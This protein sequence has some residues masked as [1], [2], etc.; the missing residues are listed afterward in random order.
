MAK[1]K[2][3][4]EIGAQNPF[5]D[6][7]ADKGA[8]YKGEKKTPDMDA[9]EPEDELA[10]A[11]VDKLPMDKALD[12]TIGQG[13]GDQLMGRDSGF[14]DLMTGQSLGRIGEK[15]LS[16]AI[17]TLTKYKQG[18]A[19][20]ENRIVEDELWWEM[21]HWEAIGRGRQQ[22]GDIRVEPTSA[23]LFNAIINK[24]ADAM[25]NYPE[26]IVLPRERSDEQSAKL[27]SSVLPVIM[28]ANGFEKTYSLNWYEKLKHG[29]AIYGIFWNAQKENG[30]GDIDI[31]ELDILKVFWEPGITD[32]QKSRNLFVTELMDIDILEAEYPQMVL[33]QEPSK[34]RLKHLFITLMMGLKKQLILLKKVLEPKLITVLKN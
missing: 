13:A 1:A 6:E 28:E 4:P 19:N 18:K 27:L 17:A 24:H 8:E 23:W 32:I 10:S 2:K 20:L 15:E 21:R 3:R 11:F 22:S 34:K 9:Q 7:D 26:P 33:F 30:L 12:A 5:R 29:T 14:P 16:E 25:D 31:K